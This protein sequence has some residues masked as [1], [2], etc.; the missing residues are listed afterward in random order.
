[1]LKKNKISCN[2]CNGFG[3]IHLK[4]ILVCKN[5]KGKRCYLCD[6]IGPFKSLIECNKCFG[7]GL[8]HYKINL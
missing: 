3:I 6:K 2:F 5:C 1:M 8:K 4:K 7:T